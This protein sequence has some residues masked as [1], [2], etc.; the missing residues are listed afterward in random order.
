MSSD[1]SDSDSH[2]SVAS[3]GETCRPGSV[4]SIGSTR[5]KETLTT[6]VVKVDRPKLREAKRVDSMRPTSSSL[7]LRPVQRSSQDSLVEGA[8]LP[9]SLPK[10]LPTA[11]VRSQSA[12][13]AEW[14]ERISVLSQESGKSDHS[15]KNTK[16]HMSAN[17]VRS[18]STGR[19]DSSSVRDSSLSMRDSTLCQESRSTGSTGFRSRLTSGAGSDYEGS[20]S[21][22]EQRETIQFPEELTVKQ[23]EASERL[24]EASSTASSTMLHSTGT[25]QALFNTA[26]ATRRESNQEVPDAAEEVDEAV[27]DVKRVSCVTVSSNSSNLRRLDSV[28]GQL[29]FDEMMSR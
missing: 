12:K 13:V 18:A 5:S 10:S 19:V 2:Q 20:L 25:M 24:S 14:N 21:D 1:Y 15:T 29:E 23:R 3:R 8:D 17:R 22:F 27:E 7:P 28:I 4:A 11:R 16:E 9:A 26:D 6:G